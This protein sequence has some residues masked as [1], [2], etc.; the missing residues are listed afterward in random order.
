MEEGTLC[1]CEVNGTPEN[2]EIKKLLVD[3]QGN[4]ERLGNWPDTIQAGDLV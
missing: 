4:V 2:I 3:W 1:H